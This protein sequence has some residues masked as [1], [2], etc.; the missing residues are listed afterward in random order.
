VHRVYDQK[1]QLE[2]ATKGFRVQEEN[3][4]HYVYINLWEDDI[5]ESQVEVKDREQ[6]SDELIVGDSDDNVIKKENPED[7]KVEEFLKQPRD[8]EKDD[9]PKDFDS[10]FEDDYEKFPVEPRQ[11]CGSDEL[12]VGD[13]N[14]IVVKKENQEDEKVEEI[15]MQSRD[16]D[17]GVEKPENPDSD[18]EDEYENSVEPRQDC[19]K[20]DDSNSDV[21][22]D[23]GHVKM[24]VIESETDGPFKDRDEYLFGE[25]EN[26]KDDIWNKEESSMWKKAS[27]EDDVENEEKCLRAKEES[28]MDNAEYDEKC[29]VGKE[30]IHMEEDKDDIFAVYISSKETESFIKKTIKKGKEKEEIQMEKKEANFVYVYVRKMKDTMEKSKVRETQGRNDKLMWRE[31]EQQIVFE[32]RREAVNRFKEKAEE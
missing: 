17:K 23:D 14:D 1:M 8:D 24:V 10:V 16:D 11:D 22:R 9:K 19:D 15:F 20:A 27:P 25:E 28:L 30:N 31:L 5:E 26:L 7:K 32:G 13:T 2:Q 6:G 12:M 3:G 18:F 21:R 29:S 4:S